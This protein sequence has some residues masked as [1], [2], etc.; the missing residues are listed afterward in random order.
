M[1]RG[2]FYAM[3]FNA[4]QYNKSSFNKSASNGIALGVTFETETNSKVSQLVEVCLTLGADVQ[5][6]PPSYSENKLNL[7]FEISA[8]LSGPVEVD[9]ALSNLSASSDTPH[10]E[11]EL[12]IDT[13]SESSL[14]QI[15]L[16][17]VLLTVEHNA[18]IS[19]QISGELYL[20]NIVFPKVHT[21]TQTELLLRSNAEIGSAGATG[22]DICITATPTMQYQAESLLSIE[23]LLSQITSFSIISSSMEINI[24]SIACRTNIVEI[25]IELTFDTIISR[26]FSQYHKNIAANTNPVNPYV[27]N[28]ED[29]DGPKVPTYPPTKI[30]NGA[31][32]PRT[33]FIIDAY[34]R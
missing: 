13:L 4:F 10:P 25:P 6:I 18:D 14:F 5:C 32:L 1:I 8:K 3:T 34:M 29:P 26:L 23:A 27:T 12:I 20:S 21:T 31:M 15:V 11:S 28:P 9:I 30:P 7:G 17:E 16:P 33:G 2:I 22:L 19:Q 24:E